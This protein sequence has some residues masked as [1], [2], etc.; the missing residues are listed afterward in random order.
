MTTSII[1]SSSSNSDPVD[2][3][4]STLFR[5]KKCG[6]F[7]SH[8]CSRHGNSFAKAEE[9][10]NKYI[11]SSDSHFSDLKSAMVNISCT[12]QLESF[13]IKPKLSQ[14]RTSTL[15]TLHLQQ[16]PKE[17]A[18]L[19]SQRRHEAKKASSDLSAWDNTTIITKIAVTRML[20]RLAIFYHRKLR[21][22][23][24]IP[25]LRENFIPHSSIE[26]SL[27]PSQPTAFCKTERSYKENPARLVKKYQR[28]L[29][30]VPI[31]SD[32]SGPL[33]SRGTL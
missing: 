2:S 28:H 4:S 25:T 27:P 21:V 15:E 31:I 23:P 24:T 20:K 12:T 16:N 10:V 7:N 29:P 26:T 9:R 19:G 32:K 13:S 5:F 33:R 30:S 1:P 3:R 18:S 6:L 14:L 22:V 17:L 11:E 8:I